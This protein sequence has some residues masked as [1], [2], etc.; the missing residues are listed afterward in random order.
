MPR[1]FKC[2]RVF[3]QPNFKYFKPAGIP[4]S[5]LEEVNLT[6][7][8]IEAIR[9]ADLE[10]LYQEESAEKMGISR[11]T[12]GNILDS[13]HKKIADA[14]INGKAIKIEGGVIKIMERNF[15]C[16]DCKNEWSVPYGVP[17]PTECPKCGS[18]DIHREEEDRGHKRMGRR[19]RRGGPSWEG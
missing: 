7:D 17:R 11:Q 19:C 6:L 15:I 16:F 1:P 2:R 10:G 5:M 12:F 14:I 4:L 8:E 3:F 9:L 13:A 18:V